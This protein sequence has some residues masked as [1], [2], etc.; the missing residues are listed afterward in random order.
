MQ[1]M[2]ESGIQVQ[3]LNRNCRAP[4][5]EIREVEELQSP[6]QVPFV[7]LQPMNVDFPQICTFLGAQQLL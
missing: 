4:S 5:T 1:L 6:A 3:R 7:H 2:S